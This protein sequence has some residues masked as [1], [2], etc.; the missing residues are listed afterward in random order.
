LGEALGWSGAWIALALVFNA[1]LWWARGPHAG[2][3]FLTGYLI[4]KSLSVDNLFVFLLVFSHFSVPPTYQH[5]VLFWGI[6]GALVMRLGFILAGVALLERFHGLIY[7]F[8]AVLVVSGIKIWNEKDKHIEPERN[9]LV[10]LFRR[11]VPM[12]EGYEGG[13]FVTRRAGRWLATPLCVVLL[14]VETTDLIF[15]VDSIPAVLAITR[16]PFI[17]YSSNAF[18]ILGLRALYFALAGIMTAFH[19]LHYGLSAILVFIGAKMMA[20][21][22]VEVPTLASL[23]VV[24]ALLAVSI[25]ASLRWPRP[26][27]GASVAAH[28]DDADTP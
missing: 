2:L 7:L 17:V 18:A 25:W 9:P 23:A 12:T 6:L 28:G 1:A 27:A 11:L 24:V 5:K 15:A 3:E 22:I 8:G 10:R 26:A 19:H 13:R 16:D 20:S 21:D 4:E 14:V